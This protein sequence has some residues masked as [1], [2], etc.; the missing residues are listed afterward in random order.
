MNAPRIYGSE[1]RCKAAV[2]GC[3]NRGEDLLDQAVG[4]RKQVAAEKPWQPKSLAAFAIEADWAKDVRRWFSN[5][6]YR[7]GHYL[8]DQMEEFLPVLTLGLLPD[9]GKPRHWIGLD[10]GEPWLRSAIEE[11]QE[12]RGIL[13]VRRNVAEVAPAPARFEELHAPGLVAANVIN[14]RAKE[15]LAPHT[16]GSSTTRSARQGVD[17]GHPSRGLGAARGTVQEQRRPPRAHEEVARSRWQA[18]SA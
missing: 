17:R 2:G 6:R 14:D 13:G 10:N 1:A 5:A 9:T 4:V 7:L 3:I 16:P 8:R 12:F 18:R 15:M 11:L